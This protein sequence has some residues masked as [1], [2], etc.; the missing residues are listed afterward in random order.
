M[1]IGRDVNRPSAG[2]Q[3]LREATQAIEV[4][5][6]EDDSLH[7]RCQ[8]AGASGSDIAR[9]PDDEQRCLAHVPGLERAHLLDALHD[10][11]D[12]QRVA[13][14]EDCLALFGKMI[15]VAFDEDGAETA[16]TDNPRSRLD[17][18][19]GGV[20]NPSDVFLSV[21]GPKTV[22]GDEGIDVDPMNA[23]AKHG[24]V[25]D[26]ADRSRRETRERCP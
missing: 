22:R 16:E 25:V 1:Q 2:A 7:Q 10:K 9:G 24:T 3:L 8:A 14:G 19:G 6:V 17:G 23:M 21:L 12:G 15:G 18:A 26:V 13:R 20:A 11:G 4:S 5:R